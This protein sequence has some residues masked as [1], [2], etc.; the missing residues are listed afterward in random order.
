MSLSLPPVCPQ[1]GHSLQATAPQG[2]G[3]KSR[4]R[5]GFN[6]NTIELICSR[7]IQGM[8]M[9][10]ACA[11]P[12]VPSASAVYLRTARDDGFARI[13]AGARQAQQDAL[14]DSTQDLA[15]GM[16]AENWQHRQAQIRAIQWRAG[17]LNAPVYGD[18]HL[19]V[20]GDGEGPVRIELKRYPGDPDR[21]RGQELVDLL[22]LYKKYFGLDL[23]DEARMIEGEA[24]E[25]E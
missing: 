17:K 7:L 18:K 21:L 19:H 1:C 10:Q 5:P 2:R 15:D 3:D 25:E 23:P 20:G 12:D 13:I 24:E 14:A 6:K 11:K 22:R 9:S 4:Q 16:T 8:S